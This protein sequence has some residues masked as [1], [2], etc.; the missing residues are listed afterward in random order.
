MPRNIEH[1]IHPLPAVL[2]RPP[3][4]IASRFMTKRLVV[5]ERCGRFEE[6]LESFGPAWENE[7]FLPAISG[8][9]PEE[10]AEATLRF[11]SLI[12]FYGHK[13][14]VPD[15]QERSKN[16]LTLARE[17]YSEIGNLRKVAECENYIALA[18]WRNG[19]WREALAWVEEALA[20]EIPKTSRS[21]L[22]A[23][24]IRSMILLSTGQIEEN[25]ANCLAVESRMRKHGDAFLNGC[26]CTNLALS[27]K[28]HGQNAEA[29]AYLRLARYFH[30]RSRHRP[31]LGTV[32]NNLAQLFRAE[33]RYK[34]AHES[35]DAAIKI[36]REIKDRARHASSIDTKAQIYLAERDLDRALE[37]ADLSIATLGGLRG[38]SDLAESYFTRAQILLFSD[39]LND[40]VLSLVDS[41]NITRFQNGD[42][43][44]KATIAEF[45]GLIAER[46][47]E[48]LNWKPIASDQLELVLP[49]S[50]SEYSDFKG[51]WINTE[52]LETAGIPRGSLAIVVPCEISR[53]DLAAVVELKSNVV[54]CGFYDAEFGIV[55]LAGFDSEPELF[56][57]NEIKTLG[58]IVGVC[59]S[60]KDTDGKMHVEPV[61]H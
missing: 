45:M 20:R 6:A 54:S 3:P 44:A 7:D 21:R 40:A 8:A 52:K 14:G 27:Y 55:C 35:V 47:Q 56:Q 19:E 46:Q 28:R 60:G 51:V 12:G 49:A 9:R 18:Y 1:I 61:V 34:E 57:E 53:G 25:I 31:Y 29:M 4:P 37:M 15:A 32:Y 11:G 26:L 59:R 24:V 39:R 5:L 10:N 36:Y 58:K 22:Y 2:M 42:L 43:A 13:H 23:E 48:K 38:S 17:S 50:L 41:V 33:A 30:E 16:I